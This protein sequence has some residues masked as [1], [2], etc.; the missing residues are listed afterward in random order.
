MRKHYPGDKIV[1]MIVIFTMF[2]SVRLI[3]PYILFRKLNLLNSIWVYIILCMINTF[4]LIIL[5]TSFFNFPHGLEEAAAIDG[6][7][8][9]SIFFRSKLKKLSTGQ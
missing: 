8:E 2:L 4:Y 5:R 9:Y 7:G 1:T 6:M 3:S